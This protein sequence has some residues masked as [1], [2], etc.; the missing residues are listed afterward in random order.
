[1]EILLDNKSVCN[2]TT[3]NLF[4]FVDKNN[5]LDIKALE[6]VIKLSVRIGLRMTLPHLEIYSW[7]ITHQ[8]DRLLGV[9]FT[10]YQ[11]MVN[12]VGLSFEEQRLFLRN[13][14]KVAVEESKRYAKELNVNEPILVTTIKPEGTISNLPSTSSGVHFSHSP[15]YVRRVR[16]SA[17]D[18]IC[19]VVE[20][21]GYPVL[22]ENGQEEETCDTKVVE[23]PMKAPM[24]YTKYDVSAIEQLEIYK[25]TMEE[26]TEHNTS[27]TVHVRSHEW[28]EVEEWVWDNWDSIVG[29][30]FLALD[31][32]FY[33]LL[34]FEAITEEEYIKRK[35]EMKP[36]DETLLYKYE[37]REEEYELKDDEC[38]SGVCPVR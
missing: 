22:P 36:F 12:A 33:P 19:K 38:S 20:E 37:V 2:L 27:I 26:W 31:D 3:T 9:S 1:M 34:P 29:I 32:S 18:P 10:G 11:D 14:K 25:M 24:G 28:Q 17:T 30:S 35:N 21:L 4:G 6:E 8:R 7:D 15:Y 23:F 16:V 5:K 13:L